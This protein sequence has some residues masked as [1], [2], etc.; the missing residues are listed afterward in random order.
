MKYPTPYEAYQFLR[1]AG[2]APAGA[3][4]AINV[5]ALPSTALVGLSRIYAQATQ[6]ES[7][8]PGDIWI[9]TSG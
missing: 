7:P 9:D 5:G 8:K 6:P 3:L 2:A 4:F 1:R